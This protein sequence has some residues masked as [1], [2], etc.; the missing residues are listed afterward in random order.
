MTTR[1]IRTGKEYEVLSAIEEA[2]DGHYIADGKGKDGKLYLLE[3]WIPY[4]GGGD[5]WEVCDKARLID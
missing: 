2:P 5:A 4:V 3:W 1:D